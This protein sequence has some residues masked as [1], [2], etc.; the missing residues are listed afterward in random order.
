MT[1]RIPSPTDFHVTIEGIGNFSFALR[2][3]RDELKIAAEFSRLTEGVETPTPYL[4]TIAGWIASLKVLIVSCPDGWLKTLD[5]RPTSNL[6]EIDPL[7]EDTYAKLMKVHSA[8]REK[9]G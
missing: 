7:D 5:G 6:D 1:N 8:L 4:S 2:M 3:M 9:E